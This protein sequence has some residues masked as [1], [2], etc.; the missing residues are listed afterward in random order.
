MTKFELGYTPKN[1]KKIRTETGLTQKQVADITGVA[2]WRTVSK[3][4]KEITENSHVDMP[5]TK[6]LR[7][8]QFYEKKS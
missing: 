1:L 6:W 7:L 2:T 8:I 3:W 5:Y 4:E